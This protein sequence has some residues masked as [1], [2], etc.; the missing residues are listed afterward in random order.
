MFLSKLI[1]DVTRSRLAGYRIRTPYEVHRTVMSGF[2]VSEAMEGRRASLGI[3][4]RFDLTPWPVVIVQSRIEPNWSGLGA[5]TNVAVK[6]FEPEFIEGQQLWFKLR[7][8]VVVNKKSENGK[9][10]KLGVYS[11]EQQEQW[12]ANRAEAHG[13]SVRAMNIARSDLLKFSRKNS[14][15][16]H[17]IADFEGLL[18]IEDATKFREAFENGVGPGKYAGLG[19]L[20]ISGKRF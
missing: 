16:T 8:N 5:M 4:H 6:S 12:L 14:L 9:R 3:L 18:R 19:M 10:I 17:V 7:A 15:V 20:C 13:F 2:G 1:F 11:Q